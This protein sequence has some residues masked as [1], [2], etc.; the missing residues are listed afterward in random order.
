MV[1]SVL[2]AVYMVREIRRVL[3][4]VNKTPSPIVTVLLKQAT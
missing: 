4:L 2:Y 1:K 3:I